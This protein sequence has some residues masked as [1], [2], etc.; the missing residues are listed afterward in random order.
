MYNPATFNHPHNKPKVAKIAK[1]INNV[2]SRWGGETRAA[3]PLEVNSVPRSRDMWNSPVENVWKF[4]ELVFPDWVLSRS[5]AVFS[6]KLFIVKNAHTR[7][8]AFAVC[9]KVTKS[10]G[11]S[12]SEGQ[13]SRLV[14]GGAF[15]GTGLWSVFWLMEWWKGA[16]WAE[17]VSVILSELDE[18][19]NVLWTD[20]RCW[21]FSWDIY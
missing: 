1:T 9:E 8:R 15:R 4:I 19:K 17:F 13:S 7:G 10:G 14:Q 21:I 16:S 20:F 3:Q 12:G 2:C 5:R 18:H 11:E 6:W